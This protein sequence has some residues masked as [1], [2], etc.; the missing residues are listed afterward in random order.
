MQMQANI[1]FG[2][3]NVDRLPPGKP[4]SVFGGGYVLTAASSVKSSPNFKESTKYVGNP[5]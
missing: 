5:F 3:Q 4:H 1:S 2:E